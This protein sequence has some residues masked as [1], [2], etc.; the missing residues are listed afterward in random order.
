MRFASVRSVLLGTAAI[1][2]LI[3]VP[4]AF[5]PAAAQKFALEEIVVTA[6]KRSESLQEI[7]LT[8]AAYTAEDIV[9]GGFQDLGDIAQQTAGLSFDVRGAGARGGRIDSLIRL[10][11]VT[12]AGGTVADHLAPTSLFVDGI[13]MLGNSNAIGLGDLERVEVIKGPQSAFF[14]RNTFAGA[15]NYITKNPSLTE[16]ENKISVSA[17]TYDKFDVN[18]S[19]NGPL[20]D[21][22]LAYSV[23]ARLYSRNGEWTATDGGRLGDESTQSISGVLYGKPTEDSSFKLRVSYQKD[24]DGPAV[25]GF[26]STSDLAAINSCAGKSYD[27]LAIDGTPL[28]I[29]PNQN[30]LGTYFCGDYPRIGD[31]NGPT[32]SE[33]TN[34]RPAIM[35]QPGRNGFILSPFTPLIGPQPN[36]ITETLIDRKFIDKIPTL[37]GFGMERYMKRVAFTGDVDFFDGHTLTLLGGWNQTGLNMVRDYDRQD[38]PGWY[39]TD[40][41]YGEDYS[42]EARV[43]SPDDQALRYL[44]GATYYNQE[45]ITSGSGGLLVAACV[46][47]TAACAVSGPGVFTLPATSGNTAK[48]WAVYGSLSYDITEEVTLDLEARYSQDKR[49][50]A[51][52]GFSFQDTYKEITPRIILSYQPNDDTNLYLQLSKGILPGATNGLVATCSPESFLTP[53]VTP[54]TGQLSTASECDQLK[55]QLEPEQFAGSTPSQKLDAIE[56]GLKKSLFDGRMRFNASGYYYEWSNVTFGLGVSWVR[57]DEDPTLRDRIPNITSNSLTIQVSGSQKIY[58]LEIETG[59]AISDNWDMQL[60]ASWQKNEWTEFQ[61]RSTIQQTGL[62]NMAGN[63]ATRYP[64]WMANLSTTYEDELTSNL[65]WFVRGDFMYQ[66]TY[67]GDLA[68]VQRGPAYFLAHARL[69]VSADD[70]RVEFFVRNLFDTDTYLSAGRGVDFAADQGNFNFNGFQGVQVNPQ[71]KRTFGIRTNINF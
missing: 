37:D 35:S 47:G 51:Q 13:F 12:G 64:E 68:N 44:A 69:G 71:E 41:K 28:K 52:A 25:Q 32:F 1:T 56:L 16:Y 21:D 15:I 30:G 34:L 22:K 4:G 36:I 57:D 60:N 17:A 23:S 7:P 54:L 14:G 55:S 45:F 70:F 39:S 67:W 10:R 24:D 9:A 65:D 58:G 5:T 42:V 8:I 43:S 38:R 66:G 40:P 29:T 2:A 27:R 50:V 26:I 53:Y 33:E 62:V 19:F 46:G 3:G 20:V 59:Y 11:G 48:V 61:N 63:S 18:A 6:R 31:A 49:E